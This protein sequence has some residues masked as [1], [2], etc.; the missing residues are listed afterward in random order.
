LGDDEAGVLLV[1]VDADHADVEGHGDGGVG[2]NAP[3]V[4]EPFEGEFEV[5]DCGVGVDEDDELVRF[6]EFEEDVWLDPC[7]VEAFHVVGL[8]ELVVVVVDLCWWVC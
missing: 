7:V 5:L 8:E 1:V 3:A 6:E 2:G 4:E